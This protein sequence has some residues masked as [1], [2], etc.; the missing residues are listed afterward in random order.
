MDWMWIYSI[1]TIARYDTVLVCCN[2]INCLITLFHSPTFKFLCSM[3]RMY[4][5]ANTS[6]IDEFEFNTEFNILHTVQR[7]SE[8]AFSIST[9]DIINS[10]WSLPCK[11]CNSQHKLPLSV[12]FYNICSTSSRTAGPQTNRTP[13][14]WFYFYYYSCSQWM[15]SSYNHLRRGPND[16]NEAY[17]IIKRGKVGTRVIHS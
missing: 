1:N 7:A 11:S 10:P 2:F 12:S 6:I 15:C 5:S 4:S 9:Y 17:Y 3:P 14:S 8:T 16:W 13:F